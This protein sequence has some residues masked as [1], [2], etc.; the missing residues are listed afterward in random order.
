[1]FLGHRYLGPSNPLSNG[2]PVDTD[3]AIAERHDWQYAF[4]RTDSDVR[5][6]DRQAI[7]D[8]TTDMLVNRNQH[9]A[10]G[11]VGLGAKY[12]V[13]SIVGMQYPRGIEKGLPA[14]IK[15]L[16]KCVVG[17]QLAALTSGVEEKHKEVTKGIKKREEALRRE[18]SY[19]RE[20]RNYQERR[21]AGKEAENEAVIE[22]LRMQ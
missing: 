19:V 15:S 10:L 3:V 11:A 7:A 18:M 8:F 13:E 12:A 5:K 21:M 6:A 16:V 4:S 1:M 20:E 22:E 17:A 14:A 2:M 9:S